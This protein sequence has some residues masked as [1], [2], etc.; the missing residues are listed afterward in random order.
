MGM[1][2]CPFILPF[3][4]NAEQPRYKYSFTCACV[5]IDKGVGVIWMFVL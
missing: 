1:F 5:P 4:L 3:P 2:V